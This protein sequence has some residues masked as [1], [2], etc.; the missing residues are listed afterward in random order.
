KKERPCQNYG[1]QKD[2]KY[3]LFLFSL[4]QG[5]FSAAVIWTFCRRPLPDNFP[6]RFIIFQILYFKIIIRFRETLPFL[7]D[8][9]VLLGCTIRSSC[10]GLPHG[11]GGNGISVSV[12][13]SLFSLGPHSVQLIFILIF[14]FSSRHKIT[15]FYL[16]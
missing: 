6:L 7:T 13:S 2:E 1:N 5:F 3:F 14:V 4:F 15:S 10:T 11:S 16:I 12:A 9:A 8:R